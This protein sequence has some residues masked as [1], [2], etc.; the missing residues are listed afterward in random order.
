[1]IRDVAIK[2][3]KIHKAAIF[4]A[5]LVGVLVAFPQIY[6]RYDHQQEYRGID[7][8]FSHEEAFYLSRIQEAGE[9]RFNLSGS[10]FKEG[11]QDPYLQ[12]P[13]GEIL[14][15]SIGKMLFLDLNNTV[16]L[17]RFI[18][19]FLFF[20]TAYT[21]VFL[22]SRERLI[23]LAA[24][25]VILL[26]DGFF[27][28]KENFFSLLGLFSGNLP[29]IPEGFQFFRPVHPQLSS[30][31]FFAFLTSF[32]LFYKRKSLKFGVFSAIIL[33]LS[34]YI[35]SYLWTFL[36]AFWGIFLL[37]L[38]FQKR[39]PLLKKMIS[40]LFLGSLIGI[41]LILN[42]YFLLNH[43]YSSDFF[44]RLVLGEIPRE[45]SLPFSAVFL[46]AIFLVFFPR[47]WKE[48]YYFLLTSLLV[49]FLL[50]NQDLITGRNIQVAHYWRYYRLPLAFI[51]LMILSASYFPA[52]KNLNKFK[53][54][55]FLFLI[56]GSFLIG[57]VGQAN[58][59]SNHESNSLAFQRYGPIFEY[60]N[61]NIRK[62]EQK[63]NVVFS[64]QDLSSLI[65]VYTHFNVFYHPLPDYPAITKERLIETFF[66]YHRL[67]GLDEKDAFEVFSRDRGAVSLGVFG[68]Y[69]K[70]KEKDE[71]LHFLTQGYGNFLQIPLNRILAKYGVN[72]IIWDTK[73]FPS[74][75]LEKYQF[76]EKVY[77]SEEFEIFKV[78]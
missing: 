10:L 13:L 23:A 3:L 53:K 36:F 24:S 66:L 27:V 31:F 77:G 41:P 35:Y 47:K 30:L 44:K 54:P 22:I 65:P 29:L 15:A 48:R 28:N 33:G 57:I 11:K 43:P 71:V 34:F 2:T 20:L 56:T 17:A 70:E 38:F 63:E 72:Y 42:Y 49:P 45:L 21:F 4:L 8:M 55:F 26:A 1:M 46:L 60:F 61:G 78:L 76:L 73:N 9:G 51:T 19:P 74:W 32:W 40:M 7:F 39:W 69:W 12:P 25:A 62:E 5:I 68:A 6:F 50:Y 67:D 52:L 58:F 59:Y 75:S 37:I 14:I 64:D 16:L 18:L